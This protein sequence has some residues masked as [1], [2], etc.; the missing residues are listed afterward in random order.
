MLEQLW[1]V[2]L[3]GTLLGMLA[4]IPG[5]HWGLS[6][7]TLGALLCTKLGVNTGLMAII[8]SVGVS[9]AAHTIAVV[10]HPVSVETIASAA[11]AQRLAAMGLDWWAL[12]IMNKSL[13]ISTLVVSGIIC[14]LW[15][16]QL[17][18]GFPL[19]K[20]A[21]TVGSMIMWPAIITWFLVTVYTANNKLAT[22][23]V[24]IS[25]GLLGVLALDHPAVRGSEQMMTPLLTGIFAI[26]IVVLS[27]FSKV[28][29]RRIRCTIK[30]HRIKAEFKVLGPVLG[31][32]GTLVPGLSASSVVSIAQGVTKDE[33]DYLTLTT[34]AESTGELM[35][36]VLGIM[37]ISSRSS[38]VALLGQALQYASITYQ[39][40]NWVPYLMSLLLIGSVWMGNTLVEFISPMYRWVVHVIPMKL[41]ALAV[42][43]G[44][45]WVVW[46]HTGLIGMV[47]VLIGTVIHLTARQ[48]GVSNQS[49]FSVLT[50][51]MIV[52]S[53]KIDLFT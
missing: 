31:L 45:L 24:L 2:P 16:W 36:L 7:L 5:L 10:H 13:W 40:T 9:K 11:P 12:T 52:T 47:V 41:Q 49:F 4:L 8:W 17:L 50:F 32:L 30:P 21:V 33:G 29:D 44:A 28:S 20:E 43:S 1:Q 51:P 37:A 19:V 25:S 42:G 15:S 38:D 23:M 27:F 35:A 39:P 3:Y 26:P 18:L 6:L 22:L 53:L 48:Y 34:C 14:L 46:T